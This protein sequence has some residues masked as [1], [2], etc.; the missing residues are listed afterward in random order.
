M[1][2]FLT[3]SLAAL[4]FTTIAA[5]DPAKEHTYADANTQAIEL[6]HQ[7]KYAGALYKRALAIREKAAP[8]GADVLEQMKKVNTERQVK[9]RLKKLREAEKESGKSKSE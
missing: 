5:A 2:A 6:F 9:D 3:L 8:D 1:K 4:L 7:G